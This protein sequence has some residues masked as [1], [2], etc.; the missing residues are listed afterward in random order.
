[1]KGYERIYGAMSE[2]ED[3]AYREA[4]AEIERLEE[5]NE[6]LIREKERITE[7]AKEAIAERGAEIERLKGLVGGAAEVLEKYNVKAVPHIAGG[8]WTDIIAEL[9]KAVAE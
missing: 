6:A 7:V 1:M 5:L 4:I 9:R 3:E 8:R 2:I